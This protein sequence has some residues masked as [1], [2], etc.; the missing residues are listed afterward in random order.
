[1]DLVEVLAA[2]SIWFTF[3]GIRDSGEGAE[4]W[5]HFAS[6]DESCIGR[7]GSDMALVLESS[8]TKYL[9]ELEGVEGRAVLTCRTD[10]L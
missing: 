9:V 3:G 1:M 7:C 2:F 4:C 10:I 8:A 6:V 5:R